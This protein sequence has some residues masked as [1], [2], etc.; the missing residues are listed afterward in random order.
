MRIGLCPDGLK[1]SKYREG[2]LRGVVRAGAGAVAAGE[3]RGQRSVVAPTSGMTSR[4]GRVGESNPRKAS[5][6]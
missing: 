4:S 1:Y 6:G 5:A 3:P 2:R